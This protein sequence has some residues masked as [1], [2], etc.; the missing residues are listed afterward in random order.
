MKQDKETSIKTKASKEQLK[1]F[2]E[3][4]DEK[5]KVTLK[6]VIEVLYKKKS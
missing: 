1:K 4:A 6:K 5:S 3:L 2:K